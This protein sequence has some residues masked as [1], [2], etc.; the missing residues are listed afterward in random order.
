MIQ[1]CLY[2]C[3]NVVV[4]ECVDGGLGFPSVT[5]GGVT[6]ADVEVEDFVLDLPPPPPGLTLDDIT[7]P[8]P[9]NVVLGPLV[10]PSLQ[11]VP[12]GILESRGECLGFEIASV[13]GC[14]GICF[15]LIFSLCFNFVFSLS[16]SLSYLCPWIAFAQRSAPL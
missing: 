9:G 12:T 6:V 14:G 13:G 3:V 2:S 5:I 15:C 7:C 1:V 10:S 4:V 11:E 8:V 16:L